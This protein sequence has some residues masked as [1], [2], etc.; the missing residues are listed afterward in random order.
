MIES[1]V[2]KELMAENTRKTKQE[3]ILQFL[4]ARFGR[5]AR[6]LRP[7]IKAIEDVERLKDLLNQCAR[8]PDLES[9]KK[10]F[11]P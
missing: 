2:L 3:D 6:T 5:K 1:P 7:A 10:Q 4:V 8:C 11:E 9:F